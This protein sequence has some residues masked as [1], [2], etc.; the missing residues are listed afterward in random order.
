LIW[1]LSPS[2]FGSCIKPSAQALIEL[3]K[4]GAEKTIAIDLAQQYRDARKE[5]QFGTEIGTVDECIQ[6]A[7]KATTHPVILAD[8]GDNPTG[9]GTGERAEVLDEVL[10]F[11]TQNVVFCRNYRQAGHRCLL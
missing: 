8:S 9:G 11:K 3:K 2:E 7:M 5:F 1:T 6:R 4:A 10:R